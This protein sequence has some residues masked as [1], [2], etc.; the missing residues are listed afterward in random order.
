MSF[1]F[2]ILKPLFKLGFMLACIGLSGAIAV[3]LYLA[4]ALPPVEQLRD[5]KLQTPLKVFSAEETLIGEFG[6]QKRTPINYDQIP[7]QFVHAI[8]SAE[9]DNFFNHYGVDPLGLLRAGSQ[10][11]T[12]GQ[13][14]SGGST[15]TMQVA[16]NFFLSLEQTFTRKFN[17]ILLALEIE[18]ELS[19]EEIL[20]LYANKIYLGKR[21]Y[22]IQ[23]AAN[24]YYGKDIGELNL[25]QL[26]MI[27]GLPKAPSAF[28]PINNPSR[29][30]E[31]RDWILGRMRLLGYIN[32]QEFRS[33][34]SQPITA[35]EY[36][37]VIEV[38]APY[39]AEMVRAEMVDRFGTAAYE[40]GYEVR[41]T[42][43][44]K[45]QQAADS[46]VKQGLMTYD[47]RHGYRGPE[48]QLTQIDLGDTEQL[49][50][51]LSSVDSVWELEP[52]IVTS[53]EEQSAGVYIKNVGM[54]RLQW[55]DG[56]SGARPFRT[57]S[58][59]GDPPETASDVLSP[60]D[61][62][63][64]R[65]IN[66][67]WQLSQIPNAQAALVAMDP[68]TGEIRALQGGFDFYYNR[69][70]RV[71]S[72]RRQPGS[73]LKPF[74]YTAALENGFTAATTIND[75]PIV[76]EDAALEDIW[77]PE[78]DSGRFYGPTRLREALYS[79][80]NL[81]SI[82]ILREL[83][84]YTARET[85]KR[86]GFEDSD[87]ATNLTLALGSE[88]L[89]P[90]KIAQ[91]YAAFANGGYRVEAHLIDEIRDNNGN[92]IY[93]ALH[94]KVCDNN[95]QEKTTPTETM[96]DEPRVS[97]LDDLLITEQPQEAVKYPEA[98]R[99]LEPRVHFIIDS[100]LKDVVQKGTGRR[101]QSLGRSDL[102]GKTGTTNGPRD[103]W[104]SGY[105][106]D[107]VATSWVGFDDNSLLG[108]G[109]FGGTAA[110]PIWIEFMEV[111]LQGKEEKFFDQP[112]GLVIARVDPDTGQ[113]A[114]PEDSDAI[115]EYFLRE[116]T[117]TAL[118]DTDSSGNSQPDANDLNSIF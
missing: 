10:I 59:V 42:I 20:E 80:R 45:L 69:F 79:S 12:S 1:R 114:Q 47:Q 28:N 36:G 5:V 24:I 108:S 40:D 112:P 61:R 77:R 44:T 68:K 72:A 41:T 113:R 104:F 110:L 95:C 92:I 17:E 11:L 109:E 103:A 6:E 91:G 87:L 118:P 46:S 73:N 76:F 32:E 86:F 13:I 117:P 102:A 75:A 52:A 93:K 2:P 39:V 64:V 105:N 7:K 15:I 90:L 101:A 94:P 116:N 65:R 98:E 81:V 33:A 9:D 14:Q 82:R 8:L 19:K 83:G 21:A 29:A 18:H 62:I 53:V 70:N 48:A 89:A 111:A 4:P 37:S 100:I 88:A 78:N 34:V 99:I 66:G 49:V 74:L 50:Q 58:W 97:R 27:A 106:Q 63:R 67:R 57:Q 43:D 60:G 56:L 35:G 38:Q 3:I 30:L 22:G 107:M 54:H 31:R 71:V 16:R 96:V 115:F 85:M 26:A 25:A 55:Q 51:A 84:L 23:A